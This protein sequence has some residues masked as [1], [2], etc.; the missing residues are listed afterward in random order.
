MESKGF[1]DT[2]EKL[3]AATGIKDLTKKIVGDDC[4]CGDRKKKL[5]DLLP[6]STQQKKTT[7]QWHI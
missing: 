6:Y 5:N 4:G 2:I 1:G 3:T 7:R